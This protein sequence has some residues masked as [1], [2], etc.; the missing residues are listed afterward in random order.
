MDIISLTPG[1]GRGGWEGVGVIQGS[2][3]GE[4]FSDFCVLILPVSKLLASVEK[5]TPAHILF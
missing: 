2:D 3:G 1:W 4:D 5:E